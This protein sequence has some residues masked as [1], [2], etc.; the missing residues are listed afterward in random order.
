[1]SASFAAKIFFFCSGVI[2]NVVLT[3]PNWEFTLGHCSHP[4]LCN[5][6]SWASCWT[7]NRRVTVSAQPPNTLCVGKSSQSSLHSLLQVPPAQLLCLKPQ[8]LLTFL[9]SPPIHNLWGLRTSRRKCTEP[10]DLHPAVVRTFFHNYNFKQRS[11]ALSCQ[12]L[13]LSISI[14]NLVKKLF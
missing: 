6:S 1:M 8:L 3:F 5:F 4:S 9:L 12:Y 14:L 7:D 13:S 10:D 11:K 2:N